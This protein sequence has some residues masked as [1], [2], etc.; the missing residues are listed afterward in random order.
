MAYR[1]RALSSLTA[2]DHVTLVRLDP[3]AV[4]R[5][6]PER[7]AGGDGVPAA[8]GAGASAGGACADVRL[9]FDALR[10]QP[11]R[12][13]GEDDLVAAAAS[14]AGGQCHAAAH[15]ELEGS[16]VQ[17]GSAHMAESAAA[18][19]AACAAR[20]DAQPGGARP[21]NVWVWCARAGACGAQAEGEC[22]L[23]HAP[24][25]ATIVRKAVGAH[26]GWV[27][28]S[29]FAPL[30]RVRA[31]PAGPL[32]DGPLAHGLQLVRAG[33]FDI[34]VRRESG[35]VELL[36]PLS[37]R[38]FSFV[39]PLRD[40]ALRL[41]RRTD[42]PFDRRERQ[43]AHLGDVNVRVCDAARPP[44]AG[45]D[46]GAAAAADGIE[47]RDGACARSRLFSTGVRRGQ[48]N[49]TSEPAQMPAA[50]HLAPPARGVRR[51]LSRDLSGLLPVDCP[52]RL[53]FWVDAVPLVGAGDAGAHDDAALAS[54][55]EVQLWWELRL[56][57]PGE[58]G[59]PSDAAAEAG[60]LVG[61]LGLPLPFNQYF[62]FRSLE[63]VAHSCAFAEAHV[64]MHAG[65]VQV[66]RARGQGPVLLVLPA[67]AHGS[68]GAPSARFE[69]WRPL[70]ELDRL[71]PNYMYEN[72]HELLLHSA[73]Y[74]HA[75]WRAAEPWNAPTAAIV[76]RAHPLVR[77]LRL[78]LVP[79]VDAVEAA[80]HAAGV[81]VAVVLPAP[82]ITTEMLGATLWMRA[83]PGLAL[84]RGAERTHPRGCV[85]LGAA[86][87]RVRSDAAR[88]GWS[89]YVLR[90]EQAVG[91]C[92]LEL[93]F[94]PPSAAGGAV[95]QSVSLYVAK[96][97]A[98]L[99]QS[100]AR[101]AN[102]VGWVGGEVA[103]P[104]HRFPAYFGTDMSSRSAL[105]QQSK[106]FMS[107]LSDEAGLAMP[108]AMAA[109]QLGLADALDV[110]RLEAMVHETLLA[111]PNA[112]ARVRARFLQSAD[113]WGVRRSQLFWS[114]EVDADPAVAAAAPEL[115]AACH[116]CWPKCWWLICWSEPEAA[117][118]WRAFNYPHV[119]AIYWALYRVGSRRQ[120][121]LV[122][123]APAD[124]YLEAAARTALGMYAHGGRTHGLAQWGLMGGV[125][126]VL[127][128][129]DL[130]AALAHAAA[131][132]DA[133]AHARWASLEAR[134]RGAMGA[135]VAKWRSLP[136]PF[137][138]EF[139]WDSTGY[140]EVHAWLRAFGR[141]A[142]AAETAQAILAF[143]GVQPHW[144]YAGNARR[145]WDFGINGKRGDL[146]NERELHHYA[147]PL[148]ALPLVAEY[149]AAPH[150]PLLLRIGAAA[151]LGSLTLIEPESGFVSM[152]WHGDPA[153]LARDAYS[154]DFGVGFLGAALLSRATIAWH[155]PFGWVCALCDFA[156]ADGSAA[157]REALPT[158]D[159]PAPTAREPLP[160]V[161]ALPRD[162]YRRRLF[163]APLGLLLTAEGAAIRMA[164]LG[165]PAG[166][167][168]LCMRA[169]PVETRRFTLELELTAAS[170]DPATALV[171]RCCAAG[172]QCAR[173]AA[174]GATPARVDVELRD[175]EAEVDVCWQ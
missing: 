131:A 2:P 164:R 126:F 83:P 151:T 154:A 88:A 130:Q 167:V 166:C 5:L 142:E 93:T 118:T 140:E 50:L 15:V 108:L 159:A 146:G 81:P 85:A 4:R 110:R 67:R 92:R 22:W 23:K 38:N 35:S 141:T 135:R 52:L 156:R 33:G 66:T 21:C 60:V 120:P 44:P 139:P 9:P 78:R 46:G 175:G 19:C 58:A 82:T 124:W 117:K 16:V 90:A 125:T 11:M 80:L 13:G 121:A 59:A 169:E 127:I 30:A 42:P 137:G 63:A 101:V 3:T 86:P 1:L 96:P 119:A 69:A 57:G 36:A 132:G 91:R 155:E 170:A 55:E 162:A 77:G 76:R 114:D 148:N 12:E 123:A 107:G 112:S 39:L 34:G 74:A 99:V 115:Y 133:R 138:S 163:L 103:D 53:A 147:A 47:L 100:L 70:R 45:A 111:P 7:L 102:T 29:L 61:S 165:E 116:R 113:D 25:N 158:L 145:Y 32:V 168:R 98:A 10:A 8:A 174:L 149:E 65:Y 109:K 24:A 64:G 173:R 31:P 94:A 89:A 72:S 51:L 143:V 134:V 161:D 122:R 40:E 104:W 152:A 171:V 68:V 71:E 87:E 150:R 157:P 95:V 54:G 153:V 160:R 20:A 136:F 27:S 18:C 43:Y 62:A 14:R 106:V 6:R 41:G 129:R 128:L 75:E 17:W 26:V 105:L 172:A 49:A 37:A 48:P 144:G 84:A 97:A 28:G 56:K 79:T 73:A